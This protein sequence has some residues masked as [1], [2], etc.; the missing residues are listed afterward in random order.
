M[1]PRSQVTVNYF[2]LDAYPGSEWFNIWFDWFRFHVL[3]KAIK[4]WTFIRLGLWASVTSP[5]STS[6]AALCKGTRQPIYFLTSKLAFADEILDFYF[7]QFSDIEIFSLYT[8]YYRNIKTASNIIISCRNSNSEIRIKLLSTNSSLIW[9]LIALYKRVR[10]Y[11]R[12][13]K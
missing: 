3:V 10:I 6:L 12:V 7:I 5:F 2:R 13:R 8:I 9:L 4:V 11:K 1:G